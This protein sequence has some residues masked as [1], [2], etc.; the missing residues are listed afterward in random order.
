MDELWQLYDEQGRALAGKGNVKADVFGQGLLHGAAHVWIWRVQDGAVEVLLQKR[1]AH[2][3]TW[4]NCYDIS[5][6]GHI[7]LGEEPITAALREAKEEISLAVAEPQ[8][9]LI[10]VHRA[11]LIAPNKAIENEFQWLYTLQLAEDTNFTL[12][13]S[14]VD[15]LVWVPIGQFKTYYNS[16]QYVPHGKLYYETVISAIE[17]AVS[18]SGNPKQ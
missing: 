2:K 10:A 16:D 1:A 5:A 9:K 12:Q 17:S 8:L 11:Y 6:A 15:S 3:P 4:P 7:D 18:P 14:E 13:T